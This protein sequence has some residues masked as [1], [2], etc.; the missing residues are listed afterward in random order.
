MTYVTSLL[1]N[2]SLLYYVSQAKPY[3]SLIGNVGFRF[4]RRMFPRQR[5]IKIILTSE[6]ISFGIFLL[7]P[8]HFNYIF[9]SFYF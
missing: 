4:E 1:V 6:K 5:N 3:V 8:L 9:S 2:P 7:F